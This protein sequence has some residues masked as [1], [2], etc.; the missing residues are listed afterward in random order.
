MRNISGTGS[1]G[2]YIKELQY[3]T[4][5]NLTIS[6][7]TCKNSGGLYLRSIQKEIDI[8][9]LDIRNGVSGTG[10]GF[11]ISTEGTKKLS[12]INITF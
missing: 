12:F 3:V 2:A 7:I 11:Y 5:L 8:K 1:C 4:L 9:N 10:P 6:D